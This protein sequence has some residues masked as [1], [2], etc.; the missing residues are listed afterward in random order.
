MAYL[1]SL[2]DQKEKVVYHLRRALELKPDDV[3]TYMH[4]ADTLNNLKQWKEAVKVYQQ[5]LKVYQDASSA[6][7]AKL[8]PA[9][10]IY[11]H[12]ADTFVNLKE[13][14]KAA[15]AYTR[16]LKMAPD[17]PEAQAGLLALKMD[18]SDWQDWDNLVASAVKSATAQIKA[19]QV[20][21]LPPYRTLFLPMPHE[22]RA[23]IAA[24][25]ASE[26]VKVT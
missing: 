13:H 11:L 3:Y 18:T 6:V 26:K 21:S 19:G 22:L 16:A 14:D 10:P 25:W 2:L 24:S 7:R 15:K 4:L 1:H 5:A 12:L 9:T 8:P 23:N 20:S 17:N